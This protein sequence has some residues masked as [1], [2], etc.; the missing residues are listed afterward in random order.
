MN[1]LSKIIKKYATQRWHIGFVKDGLD[2]VFSE[3]L[4]CLWVNYHEASRWYADPF[5]LDVTDEYIYLLVEEFEYNNPKGRIARL[6][7]TKDSLKLIDMK[8]L[9]DLPTH[10]SFPA[11]LRKNDRVYVYPEN[12]ASGKLDIYE[13]V[14][15]LTDCPHMQYVE[16]ISELKLGDAILVE[17]EENKYLFATE[18][19]NYNGNV[20][21]VLNCKSG[22]SHTIQFAG[23][24]ARM[25]GDFFTHKGQTYRPCQD[26]NETYGGAVIIERIKGSLV[27]LLQDI[28][29]KQEVSASK[30]FTPEKRLTS[31]HPTL[32]TG[33]HTLNTYKGWVVVDVHGYQYA[34]GRA[35]GWLVALKKKIW[36]KK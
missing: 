8:I 3:N 16:T 17:N 2:G 19:P 36:L 9:L 33:M 1:I 35:I 21:S 4:T 6:T 31:Q 18:Y 32:K 25:A 24:Q 26:C 30:Y 14:D 12:A 11:I 20:L 28:D 15:E 13:L 34:I 5:I 23:K 27:S 22:T 29:N 10:L 7:I